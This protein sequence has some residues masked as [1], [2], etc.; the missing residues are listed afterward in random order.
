MAVLTLCQT[1]T[2]LRSVCT[3]V[4]TMLRAS[5]RKR[6]LHDDHKGLHLGAVG[7]QLTNISL[8][9][10]SAVLGLTGQYAGS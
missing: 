7:L 3:R 1:K 2:L 5:C 10:P 8:K 9:P 6:P 4:A